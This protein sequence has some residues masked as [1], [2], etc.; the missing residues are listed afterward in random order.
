[1]S[2]ERGKSTHCVFILPGF[3]GAAQGQPVYSQSK[4]E[5]ERLKALNV[6]AIT[7][8]KKPVR[9]HQTVS[10]PSATQLLFFYGSVEFYLENPFR[11]SWG[12]VI[13]LI[14]ILVDFQTAAHTGAA[15]RLR[16]E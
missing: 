8:K 5:L 11:K 14:A 2:K 10:P 15:G 13:S 9:I 7:I 16:G 1:M 3:C 4:A 12:I 6:L